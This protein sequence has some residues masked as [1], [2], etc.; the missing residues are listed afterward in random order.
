MVSERKEVMMKVF[1]KVGT[2]ERMVVEVG[3]CKK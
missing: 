3:W 2:W 1:L